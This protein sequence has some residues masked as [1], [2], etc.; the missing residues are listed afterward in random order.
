MLRC[1]ANLLGLSLLSLY[2]FATVALS[3]LDAV[4]LIQVRN[5]TAA[6]PDADDAPPDP[7][8][9]AAFQRA[10]AT[11]DTYPIYAA[12]PPEMRDDMATLANDADRL[13]SRA[14]RSGTCRFSKESDCGMGEMDAKG[15]TSVLPSAKWGAGCIKAGEEYMFQVFPGDRKKLLLFFQDGGACWD[16][17]SATMPWHGR[18]GLCKQSIVEQEAVGVFDREHPGNPF[19]EFTIVHVNY[20]SGDGHGGDAV[21]PWGRVTGYNNSRAAVEW[22]RANV[23]PELEHLTVMGSSAGAVAVQVWAKALLTEFS[24]APRSYKGA[25]VVADS[26]LGVYPKHV[27]LPILKNVYKLCENPL[28][29]GWSKECGVD[30]LMK[31][32]TYEA[33][34]TFPEVPFLIIES[35]E[36]KVQRMFFN[37]LALTMRKVLTFIDPNTFYKKSNAIL[38]S[39][40]SRKNFL[41]FMVDGDHH[42]FMR[43]ARCGG[44]NSRDCLG[45]LYSATALGPNAGGKDVSLVQWLGAAIKGGPI[46]SVC[47]GKDEHFSSRKAF[48]TSLCDSSF[49]QT[50]PSP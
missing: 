15:Y 35:K 4:G 47:H 33:M 30:L 13:P 9:T 29:K 44:F 20:C 42:M 17:M 8:L 23:D 6:D 10:L 26:Y 40:Q 39:W 27:E 43:P 16:L 3:S 19:R 24:K 25:A 2:P 36:D 21:M 38:Q 14:V 49:L 1:Q 12:V 50:W 22:A 46:T 28:G 32:M 11:G 7:E 18:A 37:V 45:D 48:P 5:T 41:L 34:K 31:D